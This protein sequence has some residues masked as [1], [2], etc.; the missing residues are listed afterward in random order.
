VTTGLNAQFMRPQNLFIKPSVLGTMSEQPMT[1]VQQPAFNITYSFINT[2]IWDVV[3]TDQLNAS[4]E[5]KSSPN[6]MDDGYVEIRKQYDVRDPRVSLLNISMDSGD[7]SESLNSIIDHFKRKGENG[8]Y[9]ITKDSIILSYK[10]YARDLQKCSSINVAEI[11]YVVTV[12]NAITNR[13]PINPISKL[14]REISN[15]VTEQERGF[16]FSVDIVDPYGKLG[17]MF[18]N[19]GGVISKVRV[20][21]NPNY[22]SEGIYVSRSVEPTLDNPTGYS[23]TKFELDNHTDVPLFSTPALA[24]SHGD[25]LAR[26]KEE[27]ELS[28]QQIK[29]QHEQF[30]LDAEKTKLSHVEK[31]QELESEVKLEQNKQAKLKTDLDELKIQKEKEFMALKHQMEMR[32]LDR[33]DSSEI[34]KWIPA[35]VVSAG[36]IM[37]ALKK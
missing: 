6:T 24:Q 18:I 12:R 21:R 13:L 31:L 32:S 14:G 26:L 22:E 1:R 7:I 25:V 16:V 28:I 36:A 19:I 33:K 29:F 37:V 17:D 27:H 35:L 10:V 20:I 4:W 23:R 15:T 5:V 34:V 3:V 30:K 8:R 11:G 9:L 2:T